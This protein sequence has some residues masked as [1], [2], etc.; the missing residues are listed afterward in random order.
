MPTP[1]I[2]RGITINITAIIGAKASLSGHETVIL[3]WYSMARYRDRPTMEG[4]ILA[5]SDRFS[6]GIPIFD[7]EHLTLLS[8]FNQLQINL[9]E[10]G[11][12]DAVRPTLVALS[13][14][15]DK[16]FA[17][18]EDMMAEIGYPDAAAHRRSHTAFRA[19][20]EDIARRHHRGEDVGRTLRTTLAQWLFEHIASVDANLGEWVRM[21]QHR[22]RF[23]HGA[24]TQGTAAPRV[25]N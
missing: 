9:G 4:D 17:S 22:V 1:S 23:D 16:H 21:N 12:E 14:Y 7:A 10:G 6:V 15:C 24:R 8:L 20:I 18:E 3:V 11:R 2:S 19:R 13:G 5:W 25:L